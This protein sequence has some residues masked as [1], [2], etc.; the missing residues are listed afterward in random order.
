MSIQPASQTFHVF[1]DYCQ[2]YLEDSQAQTLITDPNTWA[3]QLLNGVTLTRHLGVAP[4][5]LCL[6]T[7]RP[8]TVPVEVEMQRQAPTHDLVG[9]DHVVE[10]SLAAP[11]GVLVL[12]GCSDYF[13][14]AHHL[15]VD[16]GTYRVRA[17]AGG[18]DT[19]SSDHLEGADHYKL[20][21]WPAPEREPAM[22]LASAHPW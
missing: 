21:L 15:S 6:L 19:L 16:P 14:D 20:V 2:V 4:G 17:Y 3:A 11:S 13:P 8:M 18:L 12:H 9:W 1:A 5:V 10:A 22:V 7:A